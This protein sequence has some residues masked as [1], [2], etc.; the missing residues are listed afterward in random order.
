[1]SASTPAAGSAGTQP[2]AVQPASEQ[3]TV[4]DGNRF[5]PSVAST[6]GTAILIVHGSTVLLLPEDTATAADAVWSGLESVRDLAGVLGAIQTGLGAVVVSAAASG[7]AVE[8]PAGSSAAVAGSGVSGPAPSDSPGSRSSTSRG[9][10]LALPAF[11]VLRFDD[12]AVRVL[13]RGTATV[14]HEDARSD[15][16]GATDVVSGAEA[17][18]WTE[19]RL[20]RGGRYIVALDGD[21]AS[22]SPGGPS[23][24]EAVDIDDTVWRLLVDGAARAGAVRV[25]DTVDDVARSHTQE[26]E[27]AAED[28]VPVSGETMIAPPTGEQPLV[29]RAA[30]FGAATGARSLHGPATVEPVADRE[31]SDE[32]ASTTASASEAT[33]VP[34]APD[35]ATPAHD[36]PATDT[37]AAGTLSTD[38]AAPSSRPRS[39]I[40]AV[41]W[42]LDA[43]RFAAPGA[44]SSSVPSPGTS[45]SPESGSPVSHDARR[46]SSESASPDAA[47]PAA[48]GPVASAA[49][50]PAA[51]PADAED[52]DGLTL[53][54]AEQQALRTASRRAP[55][56]PCAVFA[57][58]DV[59]PLDGITILGRRPALPAGA[60]PSDVRLVTV[61]SPQS[62]VS[63]SH[64]RIERVADGWR[65]TDLHS[66]NGT[67]LTHPGQ[68]ARRLQGGASLP[69]RSG[70]GIDLGDGVTAV[71]EDLA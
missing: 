38:T 64:L 55:G 40:D 41:P 50:R 43:S 29:T 63:R 60:D 30:P 8:I 56:G 20:P 54:G 59:V 42:R 28:D 2:T 24:S 51:A 9:D 52:H 47:T 65:A 36:A 16:A 61:P 17:F 5:A 15:A 66:T 21:G 46:P 58:G 11:A 19:R 53:T 26:P 4:S 33:A 27:T 1:M 31:R 14:R 39:L 10:L 34:D 71:L 23:G 57:T 67:V 69:L 7:A 6:A 45:R 68:P 12:D 70:D 48:T 22:G 44:A 32:S 18:T 35:V 13:V 49:V 62:D 37:A 25:N 3:S